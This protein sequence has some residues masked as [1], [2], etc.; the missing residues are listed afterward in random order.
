MTPR[1][2]SVSIALALLALLAF[3]LQAQSPVASERLLNASKEPQNWMMY[4]GDYSSNRHS[5]LT[6]ITPA[7]VKSLGLAWAY[8][9]PTTGS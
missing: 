6:Q 8:Q 4:G 2:S 3:G 1:I 5:G 7:N 9:S